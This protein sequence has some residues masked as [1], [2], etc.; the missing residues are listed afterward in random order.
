MAG[1]NGTQ[2]GA[3][4]QQQAAASSSAAEEKKQGEQD[5]EQT[6]AST[7]TP[8][9]TP[10]EDQ[11]NETPAGE[12]AAPLT[13]DVVHDYVLGAWANGIAIENIETPAGATQ[14]QFDDAIADL[15]E[16]IAIDEKNKADAARKAEQKRQADGDAAFTVLTPIQCDGE[17]YQPGSLIWLKRS[18]AEKMPWAVKLADDGSSPAGLT[19]V[20]K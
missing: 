11:V 9:V 7:G 18:V 6:A 2:N 15:R 1:K 12:T 20:Q 8:S 4:A 17:S 5:Q 19:G 16:E 3:K 14:E 10:G 13:D